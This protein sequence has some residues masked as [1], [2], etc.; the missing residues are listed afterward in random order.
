MKTCVV[1]AHHSSQRE[2]QYRHTGTKDAEC[3]AHKLSRNSFAAK[4][5]P[6]KT[7]L[8]QTK[9]LQS[10]LAWVT[11][12]QPQTCLH[13]QR[14]ASQKRA[15]TR[16]IV[17]FSKLSRL[18]R[19]CKQF[20]L[21]RSLLDLMLACMPTS[22]RLAFNQKSSNSCSSL[23]FTSAHASAI[24]F[25]NVPILMKELMAICHYFV[26]TAFQNFAL[27]CQQHQ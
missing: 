13:W 22:S 2:Q 23:I 25:L 3:T 14:F 8:K 9:I 4:K 18:A 17:S 20:N 7:S 16:P 19:W 6:C 21:H 26:M 12:T 24:K 11:Q 10:Q 1:T 27:I 15:Y 5:Q